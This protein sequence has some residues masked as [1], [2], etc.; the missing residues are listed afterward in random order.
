MYEIMGLTPIVGDWLFTISSCTQPQTLALRLP[1]DCGSKTKKK[2]SPATRICTP[3]REYAQ[4]KALQHEGSECRSGRVSS[5]FVGD[6]CASSNCSGSNKLLQ[7][8]L[9]GG[10]QQTLSD[11]N[12]PTRMACPVDFGHA[13]LGLHAF[14]AA[15]PLLQ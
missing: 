5:G 1:K 7:R 11:Q 2:E 6:A 9:C 15:H 4:Q 8:G 12:R 14:P 3:P 10:T 13:A